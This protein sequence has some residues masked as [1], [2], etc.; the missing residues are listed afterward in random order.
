MTAGN[1]FFS[2]TRTLQE[3]KTHDFIIIISLEVDVHPARCLAGNQQQTLASSQH[4]SSSFSSRSK[5]SPALK[6]QLRLLVPIKCFFTS[7][8]CTKIETL[9]G[10][11]WVSTCSYP[12]NYCTLSRG[13]KKKH[14]DT[15][16]GE[17]TISDLDS[18]ACIEH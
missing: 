14:V 11:S 16:M 10:F 13:G 6:T 18:K 1:L 12:Q 2:S 8:H 5:P 3:V 4:E 7:R 9:N 15:A 17:I